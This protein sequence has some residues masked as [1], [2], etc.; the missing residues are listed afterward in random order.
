MSES[1]G[2]ATPVVADAAMHA[3]LLHALDVAAHRADQHVDHALTRLASH[4][5]ALTIHEPAGHLRD[6]TSITI[7]TKR[8]INLEL[9]WVID[10]SHELLNLLIAEG[11]SATVDVNFSLLADEV[12]ESL[13]DAANLCHGEH[14]LSLPIDICVQHTQDV[15]KL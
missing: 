12:G 13:P 14:C 10:D 8:Y 15:L 1:V 9:F 7:R 6:F 5:V 11:A 3:D 2:G 4:E